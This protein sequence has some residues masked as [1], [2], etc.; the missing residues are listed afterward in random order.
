[1]ELV[2]LDLLVGSA[3]L[4]RRSMGFELHASEQVVLRF[5][6]RY[7]KRRCLRDGR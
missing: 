7:G 4:C 1:M 3:A 2:A 6:K 5:G